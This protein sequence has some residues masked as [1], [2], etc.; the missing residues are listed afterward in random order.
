MQQQQYT[1]NMW[2]EATG[3]IK[4]RNLAVKQT[5]DE[6]MKKYEYT[7]EAARQEIAINSTKTVK[8][9]QNNIADINT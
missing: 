8:F 5:V 6:V 3:K 9:Q 4:L 1:K 7:T 2:H